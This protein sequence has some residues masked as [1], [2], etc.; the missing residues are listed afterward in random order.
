MTFHDLRGFLAHLERERQ[1]LR[2]ATPVDPHLES[3]ALCLRALREGGPALLMEDAVGSP[4]A[5]LG[6]LF[7]HRRRIELAMAGRPLASL[8]ELGRLLAALR[9]PRWPSGLRAALEQWPELAQLA[10]QTGSAPGW[11]VRYNAALTLARR[12]SPDT[13]W[14]VLLEM[15]DEEQQQRNFRVLLKSGK[16]SVDREAA[17]RTVYNTLGVIAEYSQKPQAGKAPNQTADRDRVRDQIARLADSPHAEIRIQARR[18]QQA[19]AKE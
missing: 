14:P 9:E 16:L 19:L 3:T 4:H 8:G 10:K 13:P 11:E 15:L 6:N 2:V 12:G 17:L 5:L 1:L 7:G 18:A